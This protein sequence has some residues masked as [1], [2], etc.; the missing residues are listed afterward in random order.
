MY[1]STMIF[2]R[3]FNPRALPVLLLLLSPKMMAHAN[4]G[5]EGATET[6]SVA[7]NPHVAAH[8]HQVL[9]ESAPPQTPEPAV[10]PTEVQL[11]LSQGWNLKAAPVSVS[12]AARHA[13]EAKGLRFWHLG[14][15]PSSHPAKNEPYPPFG[16][17]GTEDPLPQGQGFWVWSKETVTI[18]L[19]GETTAPE[20]AQAAPEADWRF[21]R[22]FSPTIH[23]D[24]TIDPMLRFDGPTQSYVHL[25][26]GSVLEPS[27]GYW[28]L[29]PLLLDRAGNQAHAALATHRPLVLS[30]S[31]QPTP[32]DLLTVQVV[33]QDEVLLHWERPRQFVGGTWLPIETTLSFRIYR[34]GALVAELK[35]ETFF[36]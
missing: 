32:P 33:G 6:R 25:P 31:S 8:E 26:I 19:F 2:H 34:D 36:S 15:R 1:T 27:E 11:P 28:G 9:A 10:E 12:P 24:P 23:A 13:L 5:A 16:R 14:L 17:F 29:S 18:R 4:T 21:V 7:E 30:S 22:V 35:E 3:A 20:P